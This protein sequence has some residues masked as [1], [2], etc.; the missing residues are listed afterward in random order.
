MVVDG[1]IHRVHDVD[2]LTPHCVLC[3]CIRDALRLCSIDSIHSVVRMRLK[4]MYPNYHDNYITLESLFCRFK[5]IIIHNIF[6]AGI[7]SF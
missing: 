4:C 7:T 1:D 5:S 2:S 6:L 3:W